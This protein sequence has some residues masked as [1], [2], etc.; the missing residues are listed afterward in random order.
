MRQWWCL[1]LFGLASLSPLG[2]SAL[3]EVN[4]PQ[5]DVDADCTSRQLGS[6]C[7][8]HVC[9]G[10]LPYACTGDTCD[11]VNRSCNDDKDCGSDAPTCMHGACVPNTVA[12]RFM[13]EE[14]LSS[15]PPETVSYSFRVVEFVSR[16]PPTGIMVRACRNNDVG[17]GDPVDTFEDGEG[18]GNVQLQLPYGFLG[19]FDVTSDA[20]HTLSYVTKA[21][22]SDTQDRDLQVA[23]ASTVDVLASVAGVPYDPDKGVVLVEAFDCAKMPAG[24]VHFVESK[25]SATPFYFVSHLPNTEVQESVY[26]A[27]NNVADGGF[28]NVTPGFVTFTASFGVDGPRLG[29]FNAAVL[30]N[31]VTYIDMFF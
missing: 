8:R 23:A 3:I 14:P 26:D 2:C 22:R 10:E 1:W 21:V 17:C 11:S 13:C 31:T 15:E 24:G 28:L 12:E 27:E 6:T 20:M 16:E 30:A 4:S 7:E 29:E 19:Y 5:C 9:V 18:T 25:G